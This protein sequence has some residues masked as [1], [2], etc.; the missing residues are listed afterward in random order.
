[1]W[2]PDLVES[3]CIK[4]WRHPDSWLVAIHEGWVTMNWGCVDLG[5]ARPRSNLSFNCSGALSQTACVQLGSL[6]KINYPGKKLIPVT[7]P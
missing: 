3:V 7:P 1:M 6:R 4:V 2:G 5:S